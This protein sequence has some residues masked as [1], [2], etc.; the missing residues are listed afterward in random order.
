MKKKSSAY[1]ASGVDI[2]AKMTALA[3]A[4]KRIAQTYTSGVVGDFGSFGGLFKSPGKDHLLVSSADGVG[5]KLKVA[6]RAG[7]HDTV[8]QDIV[9]HCV[10]DILVQGARP[11]FFLDYIG[12]GKIDQSVMAQLIEG[13]CKACRENDCAL[14]GGE[15]AELPD[16]YPNGE[17]DLVG[18]IIGAVEKKKLI[19]GADIKPGDTLIGL[20]SSGPHTN[21]YSLARAVVF[22]KAQLECDDTFPG[23]TQTVADVLLAVHRSYLK[24][25]QALMKKVKVRG[26]AHI[27]GGGFPDNLPR[28]LPKKTNAVVDTSTWTPLPIFQFIQDAGNVHPD[29]MYRVFNMGIGYVIAVRPSDV[30][31]ALATLRSAGEKPV[32]IGHVEK[33]SGKAVLV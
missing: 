2:D 30:N 19:T 16:L 15:T 3:R 31:R 22:R 33:G 1:G 11:L 14:I 20:P 21:G 5:T 6:V 12:L 4:K 32:V 13:L 27:T 9:N 23:T 17:Y 10:N 29:E 7:R 28:I 8:G 26:M 18:T 24:P 25:V